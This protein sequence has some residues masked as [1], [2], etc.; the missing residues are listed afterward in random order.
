MK[1]GRPKKKRRLP[2]TSPLTTIAS[3]PLTAYPS[4][5]S[6]PALTHS[7]LPHAYTPPLPLPLPPPLPPRIPQ[8]EATLHGR[9]AFARIVLRLERVAEVFCINTYAGERVEG[10]DG[11]QYVHQFRDVKVRC[12]SQRPA[13][14]QLVPSPPTALPRSSSALPLPS[15]SLPSHYVLPHSLPTA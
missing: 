12:R 11:E 14:A 6:L 7:P 15:N 13:S 5:P 3:A 1:R 8:D 2:L 4:P 10:A 9:V